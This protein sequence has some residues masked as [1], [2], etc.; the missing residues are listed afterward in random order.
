MT[1]LDG[2]IPEKSDGMTIEYSN[3]KSSNTPQGYNNSC[4]VS[5]NPKSTISK[6]AI[7]KRKQRELCECNGKSEHDLTDKT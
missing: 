2:F 4:K 5:D 7:I 1:T 6:N 3:E